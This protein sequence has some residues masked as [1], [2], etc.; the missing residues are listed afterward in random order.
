ME[1][2]STSNR[3]NERTWKEKISIYRNR[4][5]RK[6]KPYLFLVTQKK[7]KIF[8]IHRLAL[9][10]WTKRAT[11]CSRS[12]QSGRSKERN[13]TYQQS[14]TELSLRKWG[15]VTEYIL[16]IEGKRPNCHREATAL[17]ELEEGGKKRP[18]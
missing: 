8:T 7:I 4:Y 10:S 14:S 6:S 13:Q 15:T 5:Y 9:H 3:M 1:L 18:Q 2:L 12:Q 17:E 11:H 16:W